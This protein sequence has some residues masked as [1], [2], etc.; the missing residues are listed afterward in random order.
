M[1]T[2]SR[3]T[4]GYGKRLEGAECEDYGTI[5]TLSDGVIFAV[6]DGHGDKKC[7]YAVEGARIACAEACKLLAE[8]RALCGTVREYGEYLNDSRE[9]IKYEFV[10]RFIKALISDYSVRGSDTA[11][12]YDAETLY[13]YADTL[14]KKEDGVFSPDAIRALMTQRRENNSKLYLLTLKYG[15][16][17]NAAVITG[18]FVFCMGIGDG[19]I[20]AV[21]S[22]RLEWLLPRS[23]QF[24]TSTKSLCGSFEDI[25][26]S[27]R[28]NYIKI[29]PLYKKNVLAENVFDPDFLMI[30]TDGLR[31]SFLSDEAFADKLIG[32]SEKCAADGGKSFRRNSRRWIE[33]CTE[34]SLYRD[35][36]TFCAYIKGS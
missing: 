30:S 25:R 32:I 15:T 17:L 26:A 20:T 13:A 8:K 5:H 7:V 4:V 19:D 2:L 10:R 28:F 22:G 24:D 9:E 23:A 33:N 35:D 16:T 11:F 3:R 6:A 36:I 12:N 18:K 27:F 1:I 31:N 34:H 21:N 29:C 14:Y